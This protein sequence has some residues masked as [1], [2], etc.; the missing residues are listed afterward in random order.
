MCSV[1]LVVFG[2]GFRAH[3]EP[4]GEVPLVVDTRG[5]ANSRP[6]FQCTTD[7]LFLAKGK[8]PFAKHASVKGSPAG[9]NRQE[10]PLEDDVR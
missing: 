7:V 4:G 1:V 3:S 6:S 2:I 10:Y 8:W 9:H 5:I